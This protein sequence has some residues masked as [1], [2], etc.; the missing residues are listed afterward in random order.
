M[1]I[2]SRN[3]NSVLVLAKATLCV[4]S[5]T[6]MTDS[7]MKPSRIRT[8]SLTSLVRELRINSTTKLFMQTSMLR[9]K[10]Q[11]PARETLMSADSFTFQLA[12]LIQLVLHQISLRNSMEKKLS[13]MPS[14]MLLFSDLLRFMECKI[15]LLDTG[16]RKENGGIISILWLM[17]ALLRDSQS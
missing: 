1:M 16:L 17:I 5:T 3:W 8:S 10:S 15:T 12:V 14:L 2:S 11:K 7:T 4:I 9:R 13:W 6:M